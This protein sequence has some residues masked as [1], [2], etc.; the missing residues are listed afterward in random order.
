MNLW[1]LYDN[2]RFWFKEYGNHIRI[3]FDGEDWKDEVKER[4]PEIA[5]DLILAIT[6]KESILKPNYIDEYYAD[7]YITGI[8]EY[9]AWLYNFS[10]E[11][12]DIKE[13]VIEMG[14][15]DKYIYILSVR[16]SDGDEVYQ[17]INE[18]NESMVY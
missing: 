18:V 12:L 16:M 11:I 14:S 8:V 17:T 13:L 7:F 2:L 5:L 4:Y 1:E 15:Y 3:Y 10:I 6:N 9:Y